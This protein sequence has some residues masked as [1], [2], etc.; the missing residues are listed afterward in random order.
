MLHALHRR[1]PPAHCVLGLCRCTLIMIHRARGR[2][3]CGGGYGRAPLLGSVCRARARS[4]AAH[5]VRCCAHEQHG[6]RI[7]PSAV[8]HSCTPSVSIRMRKRART[9]PRCCCASARARRVLLC[10]AR[11]LAWRRRA[12]TWL[13]PTAIPCT[14]LLYFQVVQLRRNSAA[15]LRAAG[16]RN[17]GGRTWN[18]APQRGAQS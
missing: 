13:L 6:A 16:G 11:A 3:P 18:I 5:A 4:P 7:S 12:R 15:S 10:P 17:W 9:P 8:I 2:A 1:L 14:H